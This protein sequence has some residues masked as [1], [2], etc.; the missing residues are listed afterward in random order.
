[1]EAGLNLSYS[2]QSAVNYTLSQDPATVQG[3]YGIFNAALSLGDVDDKF[4]VTVFV[5][6]LFDKQ[7]YSSIA[8]NRNNFGGTANVI[9]GTMPRDFRRHAGIRASYNF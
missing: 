4:K 6:N 2:F 3:A 8:N 5:R 7:Y 9:F 1:M